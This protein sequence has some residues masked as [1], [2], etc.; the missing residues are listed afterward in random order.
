MLNF[1]RESKLKELE[2][3]SEKSVERFELNEE[4]ATRI[5]KME[6][7]IEGLMTGLSTSIRNVFDLV[8]CGLA[9]KDVIGLVSFCF[10]TESICL[11]YFLDIEQGSK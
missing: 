2:S 4:S 10:C 7:D 1:H 6:I 11:L 9:Q 3:S 5:V 8:D